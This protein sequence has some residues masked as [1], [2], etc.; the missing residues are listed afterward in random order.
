MD[1][2]LQK[3]LAE[4]LAKL[5]DATQNTATWAGSQIPPLVQ[6]KLTFGRVWETAAFLMCVLSMAVCVWFV[7]WCWHQ[8]EADRYSD[9]PAYVI[10]VALGGIATI[11]FFIISVAQ[12]ENVFMVWL[13]PRLY[14]VEWLRSMVTQ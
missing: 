4:M 14:I 1:P 9:N 13:A 3:Q 11:V 2:D 5:T 10:G 7:R 8:E 12:L 6:E